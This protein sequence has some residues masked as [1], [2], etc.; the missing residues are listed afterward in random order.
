METVKYDTMWQVI[1]ARHEELLDEV[2]RERALRATQRQA[3]HPAP[4]RSELGKLLVAWGSQL[5][6]D[7]KPAT[8]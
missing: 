4:W 1:E 8:R 6:S 3:G 7:Y 2:S 5:Q